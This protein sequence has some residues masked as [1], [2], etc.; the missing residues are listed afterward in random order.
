MSHPQRSTPRFTGHELAV[1][2]PTKDRP[3]HL[4]NVLRSLA[5]QTEPCGRVIVVDG[6]ES[7][8]SVVVAF[9]GR[10]DVEY[11]P[12][13][14]PGQLRQR[15][16]GLGSIRPQDKLVALLDDDVVL[17]PDALA[18][19]LAFWNSAPSDTA[20][21][22]FNIVNAPPHQHS[23]LMGLFL[24]SGSEQGRL[25]LSGRNTSI[26]NVPHDLTTQWL[27]GGATVWRADVVLAHPQEEL[28]TRW[29]VGEDVRFSYPIGK[30]SRLFICAKARVHDILAPDQ[31]PPAEIRRYKAR[32]EALAMFYL[33]TRHPELSRLACLWMIGGL[34][35]AWLLN[36]V[37]RRDPGAVQAAF[38]RLEAFRICLLSFGRHATIRAALED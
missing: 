7:A 16:L 27:N 10:L 14:P 5:E 37:R 28:R 22:G 23:P 19:M 8:Q 38:G 6:G 18:Q 13:R 17:E 34:A 12:C 21:V 3:E 4:E 32:K 35:L 25:L 9:A 24:A 20:G 36:G 11:L 2:I 1:L 29:A 33:T 30:H 31:A 15:K 26:L